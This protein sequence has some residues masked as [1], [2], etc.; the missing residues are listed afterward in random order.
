VKELRL[1]MGMPI[2]V[3]VVDASATQAMIDSVFRYL[4]YV[5]RTFSTYKE[6]SE[7][8]RINRGELRPEAASADMQ[9]I[10]ALAEQT[11][12]E[13]NGYFDI[14]HGGQYDPS[15][16]VKGWAIDNASRLLRQQ[17]A[18]NFHVEAGGDIQMSGLNADGEPWRVGIRSPFD[19]DEIVKVLSL[20]DHGVATSGS[21]VRG[22]HIYNPQ[23]EADALDEIVSITVV[24]PDICEADRFATAAFAMGRHGIFF[25]ENLYGFEGYMI[26]RDG[27]ATMTT[28]FKRYVLNAQVH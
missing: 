27:R 12:L 15:G 25:L 2:T 22:D 5:D 7:I 16:V 3:E 4:E 23:D 1:L 6:D 8:S 20:T 9:A 21:Y 24:G 10:F 26:D 11:R 28:D 17:G 19:P 18:Q 13:S 14:R